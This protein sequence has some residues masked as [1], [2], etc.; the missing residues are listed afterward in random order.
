[1]LP[2]GPFY[3]N[4]NDMVIVEEEMKKQWMSLLLLVLN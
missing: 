1:M 4:I 2:E 3:L